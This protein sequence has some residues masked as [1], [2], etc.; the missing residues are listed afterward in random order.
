MKINEDAEEAHLALALQHTQEQ[1]TKHRQIAADAGAKLR[2]DLDDEE[3][4]A[5][6]QAAWLTVGNRVKAEEH[7][8][9]RRRWAYDLEKQESTLLGINRR[10]RPQTS[11]A[12]GESRPRPSTSRNPPPRRETKK[13]QRKTG[14]DNTTR[15]QVDLSDFLSFFNRQK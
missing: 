7:G 4:Y 12:T 11:R 14:K 2:R 9:L 3:L 13:A 1:A 10:P 5:D 8:K 15:Q 6:T